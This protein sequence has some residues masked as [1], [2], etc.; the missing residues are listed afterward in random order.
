MV[1]LEHL[2]GEFDAFREGRAVVDGMADVG[3]VAAHL[4][5]Y[6]GLGDQIAGI[7]A[8][9]AGSNHAGV[10]GALEHL[11]LRGSSSMVRHS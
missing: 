4:D 1:P 8:D 7:R 9:D 6:G 11:T 3:R 2:G 5:G 10:E